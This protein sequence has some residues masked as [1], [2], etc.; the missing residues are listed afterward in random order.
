MLCYCL[1]AT[2]CNHKTTNQKNTAVI[3]VQDN[4]LTTPDISV[5]STLF[6]YFDSLGLVDVQSLDSSIR[7]ELKYATEDN[8]TGKLLYNELHHAFLQSDVA[9]KLVHAQK[10]LSLQYPDY[11]LLIYDAARPFSVQQIM[12]ESVQGTAFRH[13][14]ANPEHTGL[15]NYGAAVDLT[16]VD[17]SE[18][19]LDMG[20]PFDYFGIKAG[21][22]VE[23]SLMKQKILTV[24]QVQNRRLLRSVMRQSGFHTV[25]GEWWHFN[26]C[27]R[28]EAKQ[29]YQ[30]IP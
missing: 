3:D 13:Y 9:E 24:E 15:H 30:L 5:H 23:D 11:H 14:V 10:L 17:A 16:I 19:P 12:W 18:N 25:S 1:C 29:K 20:T 7:I 4:V 26:A 28:S 27:S 6:R 8:F 21:I 2:C 22:N